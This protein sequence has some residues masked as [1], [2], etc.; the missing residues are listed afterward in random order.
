MKNFVHALRTRVLAGLIPEGA[1]GMRLLGHRLYVGGRWEELGQLQ[2]DMMVR[3]GL[4]PSTC[5]LDIA[6]GSLRG[7]RIFIDYLDPG[8]YLGIDREAELIRKGTENELAEGVMQEKAPQFVVS[9]SFEFDS[10]SRKPEM[11]LAFSLFTH[12]TEEDIR[13][14]LRNLRH[15][16]DLG[17]TLFATHFDAD[18]RVSA[19]NPNKS[20]SLD[21]FEHSRARLDEIARGLGWQTQAIEDWEH[22]RQQSLMQFT[23][24]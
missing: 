12:L 20:Q 9:D 22:P 23:A 1:L 13:L 19:G 4:Q 6:C 15:F 24:V 21:H 2:F 11:S 7:G 18:G 10:F 16:V 3:K 8:C 17:H 5:L 14:C